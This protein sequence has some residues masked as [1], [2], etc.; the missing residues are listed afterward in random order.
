VLHD[1]RRS[2]VS[3]MAD[4]GVAFEVADSLLNHAASQSRGGI[5]GVYQRAELGARKVQALALWSR[6]L[7]GSGDS[8]VLAFPSAGRW[9]GRWCGR[10]SQHE[11]AF[12]KIVEQLQHRRTN[13]CRGGSPLRKGITIRLI[14]HRGVLMWM[15]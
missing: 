8:S 12:G 4:H 13:S 14:V 9:C 11:L 15:E 5:V 1:F 10:E 3:A 2:M 7:L 6:L